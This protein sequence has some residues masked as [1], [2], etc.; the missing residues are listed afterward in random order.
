MT[1]TKQYDRL[2]RLTQAVGQQFICAFDDIGN[3]AQ[4]Q[5]GGT[6]GGTGLRSAGYANNL[7]N[8]ITNRQVPGAVDILGIAHPNA[9]VTVNGQSP[10]RRG[11][12]Y[13]QVLAWN[14]SN[15][16]VSAWVTNRAVLSAATSNATGRVLLPQTPETSTYDSDGNLTQDGLWDYTWDA[17]NRLV[18]MVSRTAVPEAARQALEFRYDW[19]GRRLSKTVSNWVTGHWSLIT[20]HRFVYDGWNLLAVLNS[21]LSPLTS[22]TWGTDLSGSMQGAGGVGGLLWLTDRSAPTTRHFACY[23]GN[24]NLKALVNATDNSVSASYDYGPFGELLRSTGPKARA[25]PLRFSTKCQDDESDLVYYGHRYL[26]AAT[27]RWLTEGSAHSLVRFRFT[28]CGEGASLG[29]RVLR[30]SL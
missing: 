6:A 18:R 29:R 4:T 23:D 11:E 27:G 25:N 20:D 19:Q 24:G 1:T 14:N 10:Y 7:L 17:E 9:A 16:V 30:T 12:Y 13:D 22:F 26:N 2:R 28:L 21:D 3:R 5:T 15:A 8:Q